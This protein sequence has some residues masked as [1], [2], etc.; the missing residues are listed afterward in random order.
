MFD[1]FYAAFPEVID[2]LLTVGN[3]HH[4]TQTLWERMYKN[5]FSTSL[6]VNLQPNVLRTNSNLLLSL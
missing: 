2:N 6:S 3:A 4:L 1:Y 5:T